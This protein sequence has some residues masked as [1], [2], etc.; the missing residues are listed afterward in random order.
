M[1]KRFRI[2]AIV[3]VLAMLLCACAELPPASSE[4][5]PVSS[6]SAE[7]S[8]SPD[9]TPTETV[10]PS[11]V[12]TATPIAKPT[13]IPTVASQGSAP[14]YLRATSFDTMDGLRKFLLTEK[15]GY[16]KGHYESLFQSIRAQGYFLKPVFSDEIQ[17][18]TKSGAVIA[19]AVTESSFETPSVAYR[20]FYRDSDVLLYIHEIEESNSQTVREH[21][22]AHQSGKD[23]RQ[24]SGLTL[25]TI[26]DKGFKETKVTTKSGAI[27]TWGRVVDPRYRIW[28]MLDD[29]HLVQVE[30]FTNDAAAAEEFVS[31]LE[32]EKVEL[33]PVTEDAEPP[34]NASVL[35]DTLGDA[36]DV[37][38]NEDAE[39]YKEG[40]FAELFSSVRQEGYVYAPAMQNGVTLGN[41]WNAAF[42][43]KTDTQAGG[44]RYRVQYNGTTAL[45]Y[46][47]NMQESEG[48][49]ARADL[50]KAYNG[51]IGQMS[52]AETVLHKLNIYGKETTACGTAVQNGLK[53]TIWFM[54]DDTHF[55]S[56][57][58]FGADAAAAEE[59]VSK[60]W[61]QKATLRPVTEAPKTTPEAGK[62]TP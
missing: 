47:V 59:F 32:F 13:A 30:W 42:K 6:E 35:F 12:P 17:F 19:L 56:V 16:E 10:S 57:E 4:L 31:K 25:D 44:M 21:L 33:Q 55:V 22:Y 36:L 26:K 46:V 49:R 62:V 18:R 60:L 3:L 43:A 52:Q 9:P 58:W 5:P 8:T 38:C 1:T 2:P 34:E 51:V 45:I 7:P 24:S 11:S 29:T 48:K 40:V 41:G 37:I 61:F 50:A 39:T 14:D 27:T 28:F 23:L 20:L 53:Y 15:D 54:L